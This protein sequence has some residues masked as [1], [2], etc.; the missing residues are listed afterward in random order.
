MPQVSAATKSSVQGPNDSAS[1][2]ETSKQDNPKFKVA[3]SGGNRI[4]KFTS[5]I[6][7]LLENKGTTGT[8]KATQNLP[9]SENLTRSSAPL[10]EVLQRYA[11][12]KPDRLASEIQKYQG[13][14]RFITLDGKNVVFKET[15][16]TET[17]FAE[18]KSALKQAGHHQDRFST[19]KDSL[20]DQLKA[21]WKNAAPL[22]QVEVDNLPTTSDQSSTKVTSTKQEVVQALPTTNP[23][24][25]EIEAL[26]PDAVNLDFPL[27]LDEK[28]PFA[29]QNTKAS[30]KPAAESLTKH[31]SSQ[32]TEGGNTA[33]TSKAVSILNALRPSH[34]TAKQAHT[35]AADH[36]TNVE[37][38][39]TDAIT[40]E[41]P[42]EPGVD[43]VF[44]GL[45]NEYV[46]EKSGHVDKLKRDIEQ[47]TTIAR[48][49]KL[50]P[51]GKKAEWKIVPK[52]VGE[53]QQLFDEF[54]AQ[55]KDK[56]SFYTTMSGFAFSHLDIKLI[57]PKALEKIINDAAE[58]ALHRPGKGNDIVPMKRHAMGLVLTH[59]SA[60]SRHNLPMEDLSSVAQVIAHYGRVEKD[61]ESARETVEQLKDD[62]AVSLNDR[63]LTHFFQRIA[64]CVKTSDRVDKFQ[65]NVAEASA[66]FHEA[67]EHDLKRVGQRHHPDQVAARTND[68]IRGAVKKAHD[69]YA[70]K[71][72]GANPFPD[73]FDNNSAV[74]KQIIAT[75]RGNYLETLQSITDTYERGFIHNLGRAVSSF[76]FEKFF[77]GKSEENV[78]GNIGKIHDS[79]AK[80]YETAERQHQTNIDAV[81]K[82]NLLEGERTNLI[83]RLNEQFD[84]L[85]KELASL[86]RDKFVE[87]YQTMLKAHT[88]TIEKVPPLATSDISKTLK[89]TEKLAGVSRQL[90]A[91]VTA[92]NRQ[93]RPEWLQLSNSDVGRMIKGATADQLKE[94]E[95]RLPETPPVGRTIL[96]G[97]R[98]AF[99]KITPTRIAT[100]LGIGL[101]VGGAA[102]AVAAVGIPVGLIVSG[103]VTGGVFP[104]IIGGLAIAGLVWWVAKNVNSSFKEREQVV[105]LKNQIRENQQ[106]IE[107]TYEQ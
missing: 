5:N 89:T 94:I 33:K 53:L 50:S 64:H 103:I 28:N 77:K 57:T 68:K 23:F 29:E 59:L 101:A 60:P 3:S 71:A 62:H 15:T 47:S 4:S 24:G 63:S 91:D 93:Q 10:A 8:S 73:S 56:G 54:K 88:G 90:A 31:E 21:A 12:R 75:A 45:L 76:S 67:L 22:A 81:L 34:N 52:T 27:D 95:K 13:I 105:M 70:A 87:N 106:A 43:K 96:S 86:T 42:L 58:P 82:Q 1:A 66:E 46:G 41:A 104:A 32:G 18:L 79:L 61:Q 44:M 97:I 25:D 39:R 51:D 107:A 37:A 2:V 6:A 49:V 92:I 36:T 35:A 69:A 99:F 14:A 7:N 74:A 98:D 19:E 78:P 30:N 9:Q 38:A 40:Q 16:L 26:N 11:D 48:Y 80:L 102:T 17:D 65:N 84:Q 55:H 72:L 85:K 20:I 83:E 100:T